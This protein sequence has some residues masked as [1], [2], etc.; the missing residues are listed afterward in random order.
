M[1]K[2]IIYSS[3]FPSESSEE[4]EQQCLGPGCCNAARPRS[5]YCS[6]ECGVA[7]AVKRITTFMPDRR[8]EMKRGGVARG[9]DEELIKDLEKQQEVTKGGEE[10]QQVRGGETRGKERR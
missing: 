8:E 9:F 3:L 10:Q 2:Q 1:Y 5:R 4:E 6:E 7:L